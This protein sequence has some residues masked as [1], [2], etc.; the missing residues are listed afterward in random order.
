[1]LGFWDLL[2]GVYEVELTSSEP[3]KAISE[4][5]HAGIVMFQMQKHG[6]LICVFLILR[7]DYPK[8]FRI[9]QKRGE[10]LKIIHR[11]GVFYTGERV[12]KRTILLC[13]V[14]FF[15]VASVF[16]PTRVLNVV[17]EGNQRVES[18]KIYDAAE[19]CGIRFGATRR[20]IR[21]E[22][23]KNRLLSAVPELQ[24]VGVNT[25]GCSAVIN[26][27]ERTEADKIEGNNAVSNIVAARDGFVLSGT[28]TKGT[29]LFEE[30]Q[31]VKAGQVLV[32]G[33]TD[34]GLCI[35]ATRAEGD[36]LAQTSRSL[37]SVIPSNV[38]Q[39]NN[40]GKVKRKFSLIFGKKRINLWKG[41]GISDRSCGRM[42]KE[43]YIKL[44]GDFLL[45]IAVC[46]ETLTMYETVPI[47]MEQAQAEKVLTDFAE[48][49]LIDQMVAGKILH[50]VQAVAQLDAC[51]R[52]E[53]K[54]IC[55]EMIGRIQ[56][57]QIGDLNGEAS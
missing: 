8:L 12:I 24:W 47:P 13:G 26:V 43:Y 56:Q 10:N 11:S 20:E 34:C 39:K 30:G 17:V 29:S 57:E 35:R 5:N 49:Y 48:Q 52:L 31:A 16:L 40:D 22:K 2:S 45:P 51:Y 27:R 21:S 33:Y 9:C 14:L 55:T 46:I 28:V 44:P 36:I 32:S 7:K 42:Y 15:L 19:V 6:D 38:M 41:S 25:Y 3:E 18:K 50:K 4:I 23:V 1:M 37:E 53:G 54:Y